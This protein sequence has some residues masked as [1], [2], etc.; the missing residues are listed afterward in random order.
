MDESTAGVY[1]YC[2]VKN[3]VACYSVAAYFVANYYTVTTALNSV[4]LA[5]SMNVRSFV[6]SFICH[7]MYHYAPRTNGWT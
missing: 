7:R 1:D 5:G 6:R 2:I 4:N 3:C